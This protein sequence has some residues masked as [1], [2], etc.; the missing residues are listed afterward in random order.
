M[1]V[2]IT[3]AG[4]LLG[5][6]LAAEARLAG[7]ETIGVGRAAQR[8]AG[9]ACD[10]WISGDLAD[11]RILLPDWEVLGGA[12]VFHLAADTRIYQP[13]RDFL[14]DNVTATEMACAIAR[15]TGGRLVFFSSSAVYSG[16]RTRRPVALLT[17]QDETVPGTAYGR[18]KLAAEAVIRHAGI[19][20]VLLRLFGVLSERLAEVPDRG[21]LVQAILRAHRTGEEVVIAT[22]PDGTAPVR[23]YVRDDEVCRVALAVLECAAP[24]PRVLNLCSGV[25]TGALEM[26]AMAG[27]AAGSALPVRCEPRASATNAVMV[28]DPSALRR[29]LG[30]SPANRVQEFWGRRFSRPGP[31]P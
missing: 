7:H 14:R 4:G 18:S 27:R 17:E 31:V 2:V 29:L 15:R 21:N 16:T 22:D 26:V 30:W 5:H 11:P 1:K 28:G 10:H 19:D 23:D 20:A 24:T 8:P 25:G 3:G 9:L 12:A 6:R 13:G